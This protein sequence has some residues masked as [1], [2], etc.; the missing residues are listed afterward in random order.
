MEGV[1]AGCSIVFLNLLIFWPLLLVAAVAYLFIAAATW[2]VTSMA[3]PFIVIAVIAGMVGTLLALLSALR[4]IRDREGVPLSLALFKWTFVL[5]AISFV[6][7]CI[8]VGIL[9][10]DAVTY[11]MQDPLSA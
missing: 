10:A 3:F 5:Y 6:A 8:A 4:H 1:M 9:G 11:L 7:A 2:V